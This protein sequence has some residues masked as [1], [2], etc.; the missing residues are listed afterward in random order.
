MKTFPRDIL[1][2]VENAVWHQHT[3]F[4]I[5]DLAS[6]ASDARGGPFAGFVTNPTG[7]LWRAGA[8]V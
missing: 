4:V 5:I 6:V 7:V 2:V 1:Q 3:V 8:R